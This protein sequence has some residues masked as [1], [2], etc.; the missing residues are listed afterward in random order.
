MEKVIET[1]ETLIKDFE[2]N[3]PYRSDGDKWDRANYIVIASLRESLTFAK[4]ALH[5]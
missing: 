4:I 1:L 5:I 2:A 3:I